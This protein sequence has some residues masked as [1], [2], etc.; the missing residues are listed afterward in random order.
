M[1]SNDK[2]VMSGFLSLDKI[3]GGFRPGSLNVITGKPGAGKTTFAV[4]LAYNAATLYNKRVLF[5]SLAE[6]KTD[7]ANMVLLFA[8]EDPLNIAKCQYPLYV[9]DRNGSFEEVQINLSEGIEKIHPDLIIVDH[10]NLL[11]LRGESILRGFAKVTSFLKRLATDYEVP[12]F[13]LHHLNRNLINDKSILM[14]LKIEKYSPVVQDSDV[15]VYLWWEGYG[16]HRKDP[17]FDVHLD[18]VKNRFGDRDL[19]ATVKWER[20]IYKYFEG[21]D[22]N[23]E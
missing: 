10:L 22:D 16:S 18:V 5:Y 21:D 9:D 15:I 3:T 17:V 23:D 8:P 7:I 14:E 11:T 1:T 13:L 19:T 2:R 12:V 6:S 4:N 20:A